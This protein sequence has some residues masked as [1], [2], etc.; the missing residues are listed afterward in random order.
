MYSIIVKL[1]NG[2]R[3]KFD[4]NNRA[5]LLFERDGEGNLVRVYESTNQHHDA[6]YIEIDLIMGDKE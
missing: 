1:K 6:D 5:V 3:Q 4:I 2:T